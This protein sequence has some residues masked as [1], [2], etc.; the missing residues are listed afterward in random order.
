MIIRVDWTLTLLSV[1]TFIKKKFIC[2][3]MRQVKINLFFILR[4]SQNYLNKNWAD[5]KIKTKIRFSY[6][7]Q[8]QRLRIKIV[9]RK[10][11]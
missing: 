1:P 3:K 11:A 10:K 6:S 9:E 8:P 2:M 5:Q 7:I 4:K